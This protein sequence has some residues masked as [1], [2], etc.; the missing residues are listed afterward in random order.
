MLERDGEN[1]LDQSCKK[2]RGIT[3]CQSG[4]KYPTYKK[5]KAKYVDH[6]SSTTALLNAS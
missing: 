1:N 2:W 5:K 6:V 4:E 3:K